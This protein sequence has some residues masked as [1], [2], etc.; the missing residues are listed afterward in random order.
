[1]MTKSCMRVLFC[2]ALVL[3]ATFSASA[4]GQKKQPKQPDNA[5]NAAPAQNTPAPAAD[6]PAAAPEDY[7]IGSQDVLQITVWKEA[8][9]S[10]A[11]PVRPD[12]KI[13]LALLNDVQ[14]AGLTP[15]QLS[16]DIT[17]RLRKYVSE[18]RVTV[19]VTSMN[20]Q[21]FYVMGEVTRAGAFPLLPKE[22]VLQALSSAGGFSQYANPAKIYLLRMQSGKQIKL[23]FNYKQVIKGEH[24]E[25]N[26]ILQP[27]DTIVVP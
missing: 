27:G 13:S 15:M 3:A 26:V 2:F 10:G 11:V 24:N 18:P 9:L 17:D 23:P 6:V 14:A 19:T 1:M 25:Q 12:G 7:R 5:A 8:E 16:A 20:S 4:A 22:T 21:R